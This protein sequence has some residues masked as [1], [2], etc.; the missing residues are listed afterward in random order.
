MKKNIIILLLGIILVP[1]GLNAQN[2]WVNYQRYAEANTEV[3]QAP[4]AVLMGDSI[5]EGWANADMEFFTENNFVE[6]GRQ[7]HSS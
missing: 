5:T 1:A 4:K 7:D 2:D 6:R 3:T